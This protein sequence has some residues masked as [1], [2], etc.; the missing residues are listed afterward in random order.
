MCHFLW[1][2]NW[3]PLEMALA[4]LIHKIRV[5]LN[6]QCW[7]HGMICYIIHLCSY[8]DKYEAS[9]S[10]QWSRSKSIMWSLYSHE[11][12]QAHH[13]VIHLLWACWICCLFDFPFHFPLRICWFLGRIVKRPT[14]LEISICISPRADIF[15]SIPH[16]IYIM[17]AGSIKNHTQTCPPAI[18]TCHYI[19]SNPTWSKTVYHFCHF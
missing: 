19:G 10:A 14:A 1:P 13:T 8:G 7:I 12:G 15:L 3:H 16:K 18:G 11:M 2:D 6:T 5:C 9:F 4:L 17:C